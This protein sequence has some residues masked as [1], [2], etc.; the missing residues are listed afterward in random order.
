MDVDVIKVVVIVEAAG[1]ESE[2]VQGADQP[3]FE[4]ENSE[5]HAGN[6]RQ[7]LDAAAPRPIGR[8]VNHLIELRT[9]GLVEF[10]SLIFP[11]WRISIHT[12]RQRRGVCA[13]RVRPR[14]RSRF[15]R[16]SH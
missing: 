2:R 16:Q 15:P 1:L 7:R 13:R 4:T 11:V 3:R 8:T 14:T 10:H 5:H 12:A 6:C 9:Q